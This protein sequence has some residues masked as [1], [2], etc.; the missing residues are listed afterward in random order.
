MA[1]NTSAKPV[2]RTI[3]DWKKN[4]DP[5]VVNVTKI[6]AGIEQLRKI[7]LQHYEY[8]KEFCTMIGVSPSIIGKYRE[9]FAGHIVLSPRIGEQR[10]RFGWFATVSAATSA[11]GGK[12]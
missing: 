9:R 5:D 6:K 11:R 8:E 10:Q 2:A 7:G 1:S 12:V 3:A 4:H